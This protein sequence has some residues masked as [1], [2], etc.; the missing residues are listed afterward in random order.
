[1]DSTS[2]AAH[3]DFPA[4][5]DSVVQ[6]LHTE[7]G[8]VCM[9]SLPR[10][11]HLVQSQNT[12]RTKLSRTLACRRRSQRP[13]GIIPDLQDTRS[14]AAGFYASEEALLREIEVRGPERHSSPSPH[15][16]RAPST[17]ASSEDGDRAQ[18]A[19]LDPQQ[20]SA[21][22]KANAARRGAAVG[23]NKARSAP[24]APTAIR[25]ADP[26]RCVAECSMPVLQSESQ[27]ARPYRRRSSIYGPVRTQHV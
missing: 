12:R 27:L 19:T 5:L 4:T 14:C 24:D 2:R 21:K 8:C 26:V 9:P 6:F 3:N 1:M 20:A 15:A 22:R 10:M 23:K 25:L 18:L 11:K 7:G 16:E 13:I 17:V